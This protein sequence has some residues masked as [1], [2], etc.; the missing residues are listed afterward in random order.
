MP[1]A[2]A[3]HSGWTLQLVLERGRAG[4][5]CHI[6]GDAAL[7][8]RELAA[9]LM[10]IFGAQ[11]AMANPVPGCRE[12]DRRYS[13]HDSALRAIGYSPSY[14]GLKA[15]VGWYE[16]NHAWWEQLKAAHSHRVQGLRGK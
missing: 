10:E 8:K 9:V 1:L 16:D 6:D 4:A 5:V 14:D 7:T 15:T 12:N 3:P 13:H 11:R 2:T